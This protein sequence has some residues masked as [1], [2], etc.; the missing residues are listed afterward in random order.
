MRVWALRWAMAMGALGGVALGPATGCVVEDDIADG[1]REMRGGLTSL[2]I[3]GT[4]DGAPVLRFDF[5]YLLGLVDEAG[6]APVDWDVTLRTR[7]QQ[8]IARLTQTM[9]DPDPE[10]TQVLVVGERHRDLPLP[11]NTLRAGEGYILWFVMTYR[12]EILGEFLEPVYAISN[13]QVTEPYDP[14]SEI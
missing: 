6:I 11:A 5:T 3:E 9:R 13:E 14:E 2:I 12:G 8:V 10:Q 7:D 4:P 1:T